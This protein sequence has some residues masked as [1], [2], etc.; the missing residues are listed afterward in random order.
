MKTKKDFWG[1]VLLAYL[2]IF[3]G[4]IVLFMNLEDKTNEIY[5]LVGVIV[6]EALGLFTILRALKIYRALEDKSVYPKQLDFLNRWAS[7][8]YSDEKTS[9][10]VILIATLVGAVIGVI[11]GIFFL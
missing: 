6:L 5:I 9:N 4:A 3:S 10:K 11:I 8:L 2:M 7:K 1:T